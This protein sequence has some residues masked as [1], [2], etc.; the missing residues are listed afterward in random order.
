MCCTGRRNILLTTTTDVVLDSEIHNEIYKALIVWLCS[1]CLTIVYQ[2]SYNYYK[3]NNGIYAI[4]E[5]NQ[6]C[7]KSVT[8][9][10]LHDINI[11]YRKRL[12][13]QH[14]QQNKRE[15]D[16]FKLSGHHL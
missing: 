1:S 11:P 7:L 4:S 15:K 13:T 12:S 5:P 3:L 9:A 6:R 10:K 16:M 2:F 8:Y 14:A